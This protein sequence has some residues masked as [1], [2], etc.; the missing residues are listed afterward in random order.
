MSS[1]F[2]IGSVKDFPMI[3]IVS[4]ADPARVSKWVRVGVDLV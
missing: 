4:N 2:C 3:S 1:D